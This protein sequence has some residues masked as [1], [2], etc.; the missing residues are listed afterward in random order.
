M[1][2]VDYIPIDWLQRSADALRNKS[3][4]AVFSRGVQVEYHGANQETGKWVPVDLAKF[5]KPRL[6]FWERMLCLCRFTT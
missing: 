3:S 1:Y 5:L 6:T 2:E 4:L